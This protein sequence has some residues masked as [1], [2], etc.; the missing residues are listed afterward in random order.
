MA[1]T[2]DINAE[3]SALLNQSIP[4]LTVPQLKEA[5]KQLSER[6]S[7][8][9]PDLLAR[10][11]NA[12]N[13]AVAGQDLAQLRAIKRAVDDAAA[14]PRSVAHNPYPLPNLP[15]PTSPSFQNTG[16]DP[17]AAGPAR[18]ASPGVNRIRL[19][20]RPQDQH[21]NPAAPV[22]VLTPSVSTYQYGSGYSAHQAP[23]A[24]SSS[25]GSPLYP[26]SFTA[27]LS[28]QLN[29]GPKQVQDNVRFKPLPYYE[30]YVKVV[31]VRTTEGYYIRFE[32]SFD[33]DQSH[34][35]TFSGKPDPATGATSPTYRLMYMMTT[36]ESATSQRINEA[37]G[38]GSSIEY[39]PYPQLMVNNNQVPPRFAGLKN[40]PYTAFP[41]DITK[42]VDRRKGMPNKVEFRY[43]NT[44]KRYVGAIILARKIPI[45][46]I[47]DNLRSRHFVSKE[48]VVASR[49]KQ[50]A[51]D[52]DIVATVEIIALK[53]PISKLRIGNPARPNTCHHLQCFDANTFLEMNESAPN[54]TCPVCHKPFEW[55]TVIIDGFFD[56]ILQNCKP[57][58]ETVELDP[59]SFDWKVRT[60]DADDDGDW[61]SDDERRAV[62]E[63]APKVD[64]VELDDDDAGQDAGASAPSQLDQSH[65]ARRSHPPG[66]ARPSVIDLT[67]DSDEDDVVVA[68]EIVRPG[69]PSGVATPSA[70][71][72]ATAAAIQQPVDNLASFAQPRFNAA[73]IVNGGAPHMQP[74]FGVSTAPGALATP[75]IPGRLAQSANGPSLS[76]FGTASPVTNGVDPSRQGAGTTNGGSASSLRPDPG[77]FGT[78]TGADP[79]ADFSSDLDS[80][81]FS[82]PMPTD[83]GFGGSG[84]GNEDREGED[85][86]ALLARI[87]DTFEPDEQVDG[88]GLGDVPW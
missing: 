7:G 35:L 76:A 81:L 88:L 21:A 87:R 28:S 79:Q 6:R 27:S 32:F 17:N 30:D 14:T 34:K 16:H 83:S 3:A 26:S 11:T 39:P 67:L 19:V 12:V 40:K 52:D 64:V 38:P 23:A 55:D 22:G 9:K 45:A 13:N 24:S 37:R 69:Q 4:R 2:A 61:D 63:E 8:N 82:L 1:S 25:Y 59:G 44:L 68:S 51:E 72:P 66:K 20:M 65:A 62:K 18:G 80:A 31:R 70:A 49:K 46:T 60:E 74:R 15:I 77:A 43:Q 5:L 41:A 85:L 71:T 42:F 10:L 75:A 78:F 58:V 86:R 33:E 36:Y 73:P 53:D 47:V 54:F 29:A 48:Q 56:D 84:S 57:E 50:I